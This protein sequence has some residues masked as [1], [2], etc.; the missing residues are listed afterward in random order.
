MSWLVISQ[1]YGEYS[2]R[3]ISR[4]PTFFIVFPQMN[5]GAVLLLFLVVPVLLASPI[6]GF[7]VV[8]KMLREFGSC[9]L[10][11]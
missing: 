3:V 6:G 10:I 7:V 4:R 2:I 9:S 8:A 5:W 11:P 1:V